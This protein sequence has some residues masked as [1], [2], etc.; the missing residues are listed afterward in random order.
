MNMNFKYLFGG[1]VLCFLLTACA[2]GGKTIDS[3]KLSGKYEVD[4]QPM[5]DVTA[6][7]VE[8][9]NDT[10][11]MALAVGKGFASTLLETIDLKLNFYEDGQG[12]IEANSLAMIVL[13]DYA[14][15]DIGKINHF[16]Y[17]I[18]NDSLLYMQPN[19]ETDYSRIGVIRKIADNYDYLQLVGDDFCVNLIKIKE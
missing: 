4:F 6:D 16:K 3:K 10:E 11:R 1:I 19:N 13:S 15:S 2:N 8:T 5:L 9:A 7:E 12:V 14:D 17:K 18:K